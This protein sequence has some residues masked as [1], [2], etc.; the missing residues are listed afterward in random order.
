MNPLTLEWIAKAN[1]DLQTARREIRVRQLPNYDAVCF[2]AQ[3]AAEKYLKALIQENGEPIP[4]IHSLVELLTLVGKEDARLLTIQMD[5]N[6]LEGYATQFRYPGLS[7]EKSDAKQA[8]SASSR[9]CAFI[10][11]KLESLL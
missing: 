7:A 2:H 8:L 1:A 3:Q 4:R 11:N 10:Q 6:I 5:A 9:I